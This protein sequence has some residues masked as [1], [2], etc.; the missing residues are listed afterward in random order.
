MAHPQTEMRTSKCSLL[1]I[2]LPRKDE[3]LSRP[4]LLTYS[5][6]FTHISGHPSAAGRA[7]DRESS[8]VKEQRSTAVPRNQPINFR[9]RNSNIV[10]D[11]KT[12]GSQF[13]PFDYCSMLI[14]IHH[15]GHGRSIPIENRFHRWSLWGHTHTHTHSV[16]LWPC[17]G[18]NSA[19]D[20]Q[21]TAL[22]CVV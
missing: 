1:L 15:H 11:N 2:Y 9:L 14:F 6:R 20:S 16:S 13:S 5:E 4:S 3:R 8:P 21:V 7:Q 22:R 18:G 17:H 19:Y 10:S 12:N